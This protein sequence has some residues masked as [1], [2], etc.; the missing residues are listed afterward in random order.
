MNIEQE[1][2]ID[3]ACIAAIADVIGKPLAIRIARKAVEHTKALYPG[4]SI[5]F[6]PD[7]KVSSKEVDDSK[8]REITKVYIDK[9][10]KEYGNLAGEA[11]ARGVIRKKLESIP[12]AEGLL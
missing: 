1:K 8:I 2:K 10:I 5:S 6:S 12:E 4:F 3:E 9:L 11:L 7:G